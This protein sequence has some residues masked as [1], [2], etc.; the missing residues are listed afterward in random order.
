[1][2]LLR[3]AI[4]ATLSRVPHI[5][6]RKIFNEKRITC[7]S[8]GIRSAH[9]LH[10]VLTAKASEVITGSYPQLALVTE[11]DSNKGIISQVADYIKS[12]NAPCSYDE[13]ESHFVAELGYR[14]QTVYAVSNREEILNYATACFVHFDCIGWNDEKQLQLEQL[15]YEAYI[16]S[17][18]TGRDCGL[19]DTF[20]ESASD[21]LP[22]LANGIVWT[23]A[24]VADLIECGLR[25]RVIGNGRNAFVPWPNGQKIGSLEDLLEHILTSDYDGAATLETVEEDLRALKIIKKRLTTSMLGSGNKVRFD[26]NVLSVVKLRC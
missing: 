24:L 7:L 3:I 14:E 16:D 18:A 11:N 13:L 26:G 23:E 5:S 25:F 12:K 22:S 6:A 17:S 15:A 4:A 19:V 20:V 21:C 9:L 1:M 2:S 10:S 8:L